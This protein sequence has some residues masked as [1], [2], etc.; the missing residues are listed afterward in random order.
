MK[1]NAYS[2][3]KHLPKQQQLSVPELHRRL[4]RHGFRVNITS[5]YR[6]SDED[7]PVQR[8]DMQVAGAICQVLTVPLSEW[9]VFEPDEGRLRTLASEKQERLDLLVGKNSAGQMTGA[10]RDELQTLVRGAEKI[11]LSNARLL[12]EHRQRISAHWS[13]WRQP[14]VPPSPPWT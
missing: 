12:A 5:L 3:L 9:I 11:T 13:A 2:R 1:L 8:L 4:R 6:L 10:E 7:Q 14:A